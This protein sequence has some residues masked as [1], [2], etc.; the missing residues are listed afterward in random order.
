[1]TTALA[2]RTYYH[3]HYIEKQKQNTRKRVV[4]RQKHILLLSVTVLLVVL[5]IF[6]GSSL[7]ASAKNNTSASHTAYKYYTCIQ[8][9]D[10]DSLWNIAKE[11]ASLGYRS[12]DEYIEEVAALNHLEDYT[13]HSEEYLT[14]PYFSYDY[15]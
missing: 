4:Q 5:S 11:Y 6:L 14:V 7:L 15:K 10:G 2:G 9:E 3:V 13:I 12:Y 8:I 1:M